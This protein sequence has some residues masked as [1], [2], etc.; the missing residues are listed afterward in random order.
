M[1][2]K[3][4]ARRTKKSK[5]SFARSTAIKK[6]R[7]AANKMAMDRV[8]ILNKLSFE[9]LRGAVKDFSATEI[10]GLIRE[11]RKNSKQISANKGHD[12]EKLL[13]NLVGIQYE[14]SVSERSR[15]K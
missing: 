4:R 11:I 6:R 9:V 3:R 15:R 7:D 10:G 2:V 13:Q 12:T 1:P 14:K 5:S 8:A